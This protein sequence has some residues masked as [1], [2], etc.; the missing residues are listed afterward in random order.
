MRQDEYGQ[1]ILTESELCDLYMKDPVRSLGSCFV[2]KAID[3]HIDLEL[4]QVPRLLTYRHPATSVTEFDSINQK[5]WY[6]P[7]QYKNMDIAAWILDKCQTDQERQRVGQELL[8]FLERDLFDMLKY[9]KYLVDTMRVNNIVWGVGRGSS[10]SSYVLFL[11]GVHK[12]NSLYFGLEIG[13]F[14]K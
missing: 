8:L 10:V 7:E 1:Y 5:N 2:N 13:E 4:E 14:L 12:I 9:L 3:F 11:L 6:M